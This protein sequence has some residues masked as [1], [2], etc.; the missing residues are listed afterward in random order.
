MRTLRASHLR[1][2]CG[3]FTVNLGLKATSKSV[4]WKDQMSDI[5]GELAGGLKRLNGIKKDL[6]DLEFK[7]EILLQRS[8][9]LDAKEEVL[10]L[11]F[12]KI[13]NLF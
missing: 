7:E 6:G 13:L 8:L 9:L 10:L 3:G 11:P 1:K 12:Y 5:L 2:G 4:F